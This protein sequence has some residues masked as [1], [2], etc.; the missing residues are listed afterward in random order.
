MSIINGFNLKHGTHLLLLK[1]ANLFNKTF[2]LNAIPNFSCKLSQKI[3]NFLWNQFLVAIK[4]KFVTNITTNERGMQKWMGVESCLWKSCPINCNLKRERERNVNRR[5]RGGSKGKVSSYLFAKC[6]IRTRF[7]TW[8]S[9][10][11]D[12]KKLRSLSK[13]KIDFFIDISWMVFCKRCKTHD[14]LDNFSY[15]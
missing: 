9:S 11:N 6:A 1:L 15:N 7:Y 2:E 3:N 12:S 4:S 10:E 8:M 5:R 14:I 13:W